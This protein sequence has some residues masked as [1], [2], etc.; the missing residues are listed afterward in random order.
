MYLLGSPA[1]FLKAIM[2]VLSQ[3]EVKLEW[4]DLDAMVFHERTNG[5]RS[6]GVHVSGILKHIAL[7]MNMFKEEDRQDEFPL[8]ML[9]GMGFEEQ[10]ARLYENVW[11][12]PGEYALFE[13]EEGGAVY[14]WPDGLEA[15]EEEEREERLPSTDWIVHEF[16]YTGK[17]M[18]GREDIRGEWLWMQQV[19][20]YVN[21]LRAR[22]LKSNKGMFH[23][24]WKYGDYKYPLTERYV[25]YL[26]EFEEKELEG[27]LKMLR[28]H[29]S[30]VM[31]E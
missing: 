18:R 6:E 26:V 29:R 13:G 1:F 21:M 7:K 31:Y 8:R 2:K 5:A 23:I 11:W 17:S 28:A 24:C 15:I 22:G 4:S 27:N 19:M 30:E 12:Q 16:K 25:R 20:A 9:L 3:V 14:G 10:A